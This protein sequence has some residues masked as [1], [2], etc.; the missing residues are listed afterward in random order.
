MYSF[1]QH[2]EMRKDTLLYNLKEIEVNSSPIVT[3]VKNLNKGRSIWVLDNINQLPQILGYSDPIKYTQTLPGIQTNNEYDCGLHIYGCD[4]S[5]N[6]MSIENVPIYNT[7]HLLG[8]FSSFNAS[9]FSKLSIDKVA[10][11]SKFPNRLGGMLS[12]NLHNEI[13]DSIEADITI[14]MI[15]SQG[16]IKLPITP[17]SMFAVSARLCYINLLY[18]KALKLDNNQL[19]YTFG[20]INAT[21]LYKPNKNNTIQIS[22]FFSNDKASLFEMSYLADLKLNW[23]NKMIFSQWEHIFQESKK[24]KQTLYYTAYKSKLSLYQ[25]SINLKL[26]SSISDIGYNAIFTK[27]NFNAGLNAIWHNISPQTPLISGSYNSKNNQKEQKLFTQEYSANADGLIAITSDLV[28]NIG[29]RSSMYVDNDKKVFFAFD[30][31]ISLTLAKTKW[32]ISFTASMR[33]QFIYQTGFSSI[34]FP[35]EFWMSCNDKFK[36]Q[37]A[38]NFVS[39]FGYK[40]MPGYHISTELYYKRLHNIVEYNGNVLDFIQTDYNLNNHLFQGNGF[41]YGVNVMLNKTSGKLIGWIGYNIGRALRNFNDKG[42]N[43]KYPANHERIHELNIV[44]TYNISSNWDIG[45]TYIFASGTPFTAPKYFY[46]FAGNLIT[47]YG[48]HNAFRLKPYSRLDISINYKFHL[49][50]TDECG[51]NF[52]IYNLLATKNELFWQWKI[53]DGNLLQYRPI[54]F[55]FNFIP[56]ISFY[57]KL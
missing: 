28:S 25:E 30:P 53:K 17:K 56:S 22:S 46:V 31:S 23:D 7:S 3:P 11:N 9:H 18:S 32:D 35:T 8:L 57:I 26:P 12:M 21:W 40:L 16:S 49:P 54:S 20:D 10:I 42:L 41:N 15:S 36:P 43:G 50:H 48:K 47:Q 2:E 24:I 4:N 51:L 19:K 55:P 1:S 6:Y 29:V 33:H 37:S 27:R 39:T 34:G 38:I 52:S 5:H 45:A 13:S 14:G 44:S